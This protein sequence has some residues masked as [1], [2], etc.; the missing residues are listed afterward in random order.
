MLSAVAA[1]TLW[2]WH[3]F[4]SLDERLLWQSRNVEWWVMVVNAERSRHWKH[5]TRGVLRR[6]GRTVYPQGWSVVPRPA[7]RSSLPVPYT[8][9]EEE[10]FRVGAGLARGGDRAGRMWVVAACLGAGLLGSELG[11]AVVDDVVKLGAGRLGVRISRSRN[12]RLV[13]MRLSYTDLVKRAARTANAGGGRFVRSDCRNA[14]YD[15]ASGLAPKGGAGLMLR[16]ARVT[17]LAAHVEAGTG[18]AVLRA[19][20]GPVSSCTLT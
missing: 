20:A 15:L 19:I 13:P 6:V 14:V 8:Q 10:T 3:R 4:G 9:R 1:I 16:R 12:P 7:G 18:L 2:G 11:E 17:W 5:N